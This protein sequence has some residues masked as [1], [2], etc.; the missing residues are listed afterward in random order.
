VSLPLELQ[1]YRWATILASPLTGLIL[2]HRAK[3][4]KEDPAR[5]NE[6]RGRA[7]HDRPLGTLVWLHAASVGE[8]LLALELVHRLSE[9]SD[10]Q[11]LVTTGTTT[12]AELMATRLPA[13]AR[14]QYM[15][16]DQPAC[17]RR[18]LDHWTPD[19]AIFLESELWPNLLLEIKARGIPAALA[20][21]R[22]NTKSLTNWGRR[23][24]AISC[25]LEAFQWIGAADERT[26]RGLGEF[27]DQKIHTIGNLKLQIKPAPVDPDKLEAARA[28]LECRP[29]W[30]AAST[31]EGEEDSVLRAHDQWLK[32]HPDGLLILAPRHPERASEIAKAIRFA[33]FGHCLR[34]TGE[35]PRKDE[36]I[37][38]ADT[39]GEMPI[40][41]A[42]A[43]WAFI[44]GSL[45]DGIGG[46]NPVEATQHG[47]SVMTG[48]FTASFD[49]V[50]EAY[51]SVGA[52]VQV[53]AGSEIPAALEMNPASYLENARMALANLTGEAMTETLAAI[54]DLLPQEQI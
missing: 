17:V 8:S 11:F 45:I 19:V 51:K 4:G 24:A 50:F 10:S 52:V 49:D 6:R 1:L 23:R 35:F 48:P 37:W 34:S 16:I 5:L 7:E 27:T 18:F 42:L 30:L 39:L 3:K 21:A 20:N 53:I 46:H 29:V 36:E 32:S 47:C 54:S 38:L 26:A 41:Y 31:H 40:W 25:L 28:I 15:P 22:M 12:S 9:T 33:K 44:G 14:H 43:E 13:R 2:N